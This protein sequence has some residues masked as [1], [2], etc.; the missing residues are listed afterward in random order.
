[1]TL[2]EMIER[3]IQQM[4]RQPPTEPQPVPEPRE[5]AAIERMVRAAMPAVV[6]DMKARRAAAQQINK[7]QQKQEAA[8]SVFFQ[9]QMPKE[10]DGETA[11]EMSDPN[12]V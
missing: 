10:S 4:R 2:D 6:R 3:E 12:F 5:S 9:Q 11:Y 8:T 1:M 7:T